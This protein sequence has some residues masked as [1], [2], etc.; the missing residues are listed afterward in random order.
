MALHI[1]TSAATPIP[2]SAG[3]LIMVNAALTGTITVADTAGT[4]GIITN[5]TVGNQFLYYGAN[6]AFTVTASTTCDLS[7]SV[8]SRTV[9]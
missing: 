3:I 1:T 8:L 4:Q 9:M 5:P 2:L 7:V 6:G